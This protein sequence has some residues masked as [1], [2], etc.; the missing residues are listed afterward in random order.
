MLET[1]KKEGDKAV[2]KNQKRIAKELKNKKFVSL[3]DYIIE[4]IK[5]K[6]AIFWFQNF[7]YL[8]I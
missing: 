7:L 6:L 8:P 1:I 3:N 5:K 2:G 4:R